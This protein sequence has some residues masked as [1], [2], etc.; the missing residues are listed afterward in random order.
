MSIF[1]K[2]E[3]VT[4][5]KQILIPPITITIMFLLVY[6]FAYVEL[7]DIRKQNIKIRNW[8]TLS[9]SL[10][11]STVITKN[12]QLIVQQLSNNGDPDALYFRYLDNS[13][14]LLALFE[15][16]KYHP[17]TN[18]YSAAKLSQLENLVAYRNKLNLKKLNTAFSQLIPFL[19]TS[20]RN[21]HAKKRYAYIR[22]YDNVNQT[23][24]RTIKYAGIGLIIAILVCIALL[25]WSSS[26]SGSPLN[27]I[28]ELN[29]Q[30]SNLLGIATVDHKNDL[31]TNLQHTLQQTLSTL[32]LNTSPRV[33]IES[34]EKER[35][36][37]ARDMH[38]QT[39]SDLT[40]LS[41][42]IDKIDF[43]ATEATNSD[44]SVTTNTG[45]DAQ[46]PSALKTS[47]LDQI[48]LIKVGIRKIIDDLH[49]QEL[50]LIGLGAAIKSHLEK[51]CSNDNLPDWKTHID[52]EACSALDKSEQLHLY[53]ISLE[54]INNILKHARCD[55]YEISLVRSANTI[56]LLAEDNGIGFNTQQTQTHQ[57]HG[58]N[59]IKERAI[60][61]KGHAKW[62][63]SRF[64]SGCRFEL[65][66]NTVK[67]RK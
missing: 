39:L 27:K 29:R 38:D 14:R 16:I 53:R 54:V 11:R 41:R 31:L 4:Y 30:I 18:S 32:T 2:Q 63:T 7:S 12:M 46:N 28:A 52:P 5:N 36:R 47:L 22:Y 62:D 51:Y 40:N 19:N 13:N 33:L 25:Y 6:L 65:I 67:I 58:I 55:R 9:N 24:I 49:P 42:E 56:T 8:A 34:T 15:Q 57:G 10:E 35:S 37:I 20:Y 23:T 44:A 3:N 21:A 59:N 1:N 26:K 45:D 48:T 61:I 43:S 60:L 17:H 50:D 66:I 64:S